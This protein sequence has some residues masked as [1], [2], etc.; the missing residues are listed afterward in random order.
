[1]ER[2]DST[3]IIRLALGLGLL[4]AACSSGRT[5]AAPELA[6]SQV[7]YLSHV[8][9]VDAAEALCG[10]FAQ[11]SGAGHL[12]HPGCRH[13]ATKPGGA[14]AAPAVWLSVTSEPRTNALIIAASPGHADQLERALEIVKELDVPAAAAKG[15]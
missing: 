3:W 13:A 15:S 5:S 7:V 9:A 2:H 6:P 11:E 4:L 14:A 1:M 12:Q 10:R 8:S